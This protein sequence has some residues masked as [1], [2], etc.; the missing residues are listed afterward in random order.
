MHN[1]VTTFTR[2]FARTFAGLALLALVLWL[3]GV[4]MEAWQVTALLLGFALL[5]GARELLVR[6]GGQ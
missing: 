4:S 3:A 1:A 2:G 6:R 5:G